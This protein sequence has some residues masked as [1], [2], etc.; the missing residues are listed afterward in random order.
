MLHSVRWKSTALALAFCL[1]LAVAPARAAAET[2]FADLEGHWSAE[3]ALWCVEEGLMNGVGGGAFQPDAPMTRGMLVTVLHRLAGSPAPEAPPEAPAPS[4]SPEGGASPEPSEPPS[5]AETPE[6][7]EEPA[8]PESP[9]PLENPET[10]TPEPSE[11]PAP[12]ASP[13]PSEK[14]VPSE[15]PVPSEP[16]ETT[17]GFTDVPPE[18]WY[19]QAVAWAAENGIVTGYTESLF[20]PEE[21]IS[22]EQLA[23]VLYRYAVWSGRDL[24]EESGGAAFADQESI[25]AW[26]REAVAWAAAEGIIGGREGNRF[27]PGDKASRGEVATM[28]RRYVTGE[29]LAQPPA[30]EP[31]TASV[32]I[33]LYHHIADSGDPSTTIS[34]A[35]LEE[36]FQAILAAGYVPVSLQALRDFVLEGAALPENAVCITFDDG[37]TSNYDLAFPLLQKYSIPAAIFIVGVH[38]GADTYRDTDYPITPHFTYEQAREMLASGLVEIQS[39]TY[40]MHRLA[41]YEPPENPARVNA[42]RL[43]TES[44]QHYT[45]ALTADYQRSVAE[46]LENTGEK[47]T[48]LAYPGG[49]WSTESEAILKAAGAE[50]T[51]TTAEGAARLVQG[52]P[53]SLYL[54]P[55]NTVS[56]SLSAQGLLDV[57]EA[58]SK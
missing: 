2:G 32:P 27:A 35:L 37:Y 19:A 49:A 45:A 40:D 48:C 4:E 3:A 22:R 1:L 8:L 11:T 28:L 56:G 57:L 14:P 58:L 46:I 43:P 55:R 41:E 6:P 20:C 30:P 16:P 5:P 9:V 7:S 47:A 31:E 36:H 15:S 21:N 25:S 23:A 39:H 17:A 26:A 53:E 51:L 42:L 18:S 34:A 52:D 44:L 38:V 29:D 54:L 13:E 24:P 33:L 10:A 12:S 50:M